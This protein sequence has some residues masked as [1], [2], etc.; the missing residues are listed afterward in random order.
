[1]VYHQVPRHLIILRGNDDPQNPIPVVIPPDLQKFFIVNA[2]GH[3]SG[4][5]LIATCSYR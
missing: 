1:M 5:S 4:I 3:N 2:P